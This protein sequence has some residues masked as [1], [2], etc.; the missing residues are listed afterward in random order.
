MA[1]VFPLLVLAVAAL[2]YLAPRAVFL[3]TTAI[4]AV[5]L[6]LR[7]WSRPQ[8][9]LLNSTVKPS[10][11][12]RYHEEKVLI[13]SSH[14]LITTTKVPSDIDYIIIGSGMSGLTCAAVLSRCGYRV[15]VL[16]Q[17]DRAGGGTHMYDFQGFHFDAG[18]HYTIPWSGPLLG[19]AA[20]ASAPKVEFKKMGE[21]VSYW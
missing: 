6:I 7:E 8:K 20:G 2:T 3:L 9:P 11:T 12:S 17:H 18:L 5:V 13:V 21:E 19:L 4:T 1:K 10:I 14:G 15:V 16:E